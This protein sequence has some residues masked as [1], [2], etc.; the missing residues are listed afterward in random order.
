MQLDDAARAFAEG[1]VTADVHA[2]PQ[3]RRQ[4][5]P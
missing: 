2:P 5:Q 1:Q 3:P 4:Q